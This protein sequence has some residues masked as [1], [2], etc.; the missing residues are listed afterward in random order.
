MCVIGRL[1]EW[2][3]AQWDELRHAAAVIGAVLCVCVQPRFWTRAVRKAFALQLLSV[4]VEPLWFVG[5]VAMFVG[6]S[7]EALLARANEMM[8]ELQNVTTNLNVAVK[9]VQ[10][11]TSRLPEI[12]DAVADETKDLPGLVRQTQASM[13]ELERLVEAM[14]KTW[15]LRKY[16]NKT[17]PPPLNPLSEPVSPLEKPVNVSH[18]P[19]DSAR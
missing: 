2:V 13:R 15:L 12:T 6:I 18:S 19:R 17:N 8:G 10:N 16:V 4:G 3:W 7:V 11:G 14:Q 1:G 9:N 5:A